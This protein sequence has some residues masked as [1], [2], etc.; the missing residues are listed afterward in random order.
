MQRGFKPSFNHDEVIWMAFEDQ[1]PVWKVGCKMSHEGDVN[2]SHD[3]HYLSH[4]LLRTTAAMSGLAEN[5]VCG[6]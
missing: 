4:G 5:K 2:L 6:S 1:E 3:G